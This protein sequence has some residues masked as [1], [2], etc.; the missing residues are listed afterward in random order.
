MYRGDDDCEQCTFRDIAYCNTLKASYCSL[1]MLLLSR[2]SFC[3]KHKN[4]QLSV[5]QA[6]QLRNIDKLVSHSSRLWDAHKQDGQI[7][8]RQML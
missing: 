1:C 4:N 3:K 7:K 2:W 5:A 6:T 8:H